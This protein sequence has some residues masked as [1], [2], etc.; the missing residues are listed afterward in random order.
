MRISLVVLPVAVLLQLATPAV[1][2]SVA[3]DFYDIP[4][5]PSTVFV[6]VE[7]G[8]VIRG[9]LLDRDGKSLT[10]LVGEQEVRFDRTEVRRIFR[11]RGP[12]L[13]AVRT[14]GRIGLAAG[15]AIGLAL[16]VEACDANHGTDRVL[17]LGFAKGAVTFVVSLTTVGLGTLVALAIDRLRATRLVIY[18]RPSGSTFALAPVIARDRKGLSLSIGW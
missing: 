9:I 14:G 8:V 7:G 18:E 1:A 12:S 16:P 6:E 4:N 5:V 13:D 15:L 10:V 3:T 2:Q 11:K 17:C